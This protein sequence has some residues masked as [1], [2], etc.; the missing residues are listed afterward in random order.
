[1]QK[2]K[3]EQSS[4]ETE[5]SIPKKNTVAH[6][7]LYTLSGI[8]E[9]E[10]SSGCNEAR[11]DGVTP[12][13]VYKF[14]AGDDSIVFDNVREISSALSKLAD[15]KEE[16]HYNR[17]CERKSE[18]TDWEGPD[19]RY[20]YRITSFGRMLLSSLGTPDK[21]PNRRYYDTGDRDISVLPNHDPD[22]WKDT[23]EL[24]SSEWNPYDNE[25]VPTSIDNAYF[26]NEAQEETVKRRG[27]M[28]LVEELAEAFPDVTFVVGCKPFASYDLA[29]AIRDPWTPVVQFSIYTSL[30][31]H[32]PDDEINAYFTSLVEE[33][34][35]ALEQ[36]HMEAG[37]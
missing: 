26:K 3:Q 8:E 34:H 4:D 18:E 27:Y 22:W 10:A 5:Y 24:Y 31:L 2:Q 12:E 11:Q 33:L 36:E 35:H 20:R 17:V 32:R 28:H 7:T 23:H 9:S 16:W 29:Y 13:R 30:A 37:E 6:W 25:W 21:L 1:M 14:A 19:V 15:R